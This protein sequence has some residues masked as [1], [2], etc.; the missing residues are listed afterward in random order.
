MSESMTRRTFLVLSS[1]A[2]TSVVF[3]SCAPPM[4][5]QLRKL[6]VAIALDSSTQ[7][8]ELLPF[9]ESPQSE[10]VALVG[11]PKGSLQTAS[12]I[13][14]S[15]FRSIDLGAHTNDLSRT[16]SFDALVWL[17]K[18]KTDRVLLHAITSGKHVMLASPVIRLSKSDLGGLPSQ[19]IIQVLPARV[20]FNVGI[21]ITASESVRQVRIIRQP[22]RHAFPISS[23]YLEENIHDELMVAQA[24]FDG[25]TL[26]PQDLAVCDAPHGPLWS[27]RYRVSGTKGACGEVHTSVSAGDRHPLDRMIVKTDRRSIDFPIVPRCADVS[28][29]YFNEFL[30]AIGRVDRA[31]LLGSID[32]ALAISALISTSKSQ[33]EPFDECQDHEI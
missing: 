14:F 17:R 5:G 21:T 8:D 12:A 10:I 7:I 33:R 9:A 31:S 23:E 2:G 22:P 20:P 29:I 11:L 15:K 19:Q 27:A 18:S 28:H 1:M 6:R 32:E 24:L 3:A 25:A 16:D 30:S 4:F 26:I 13:A